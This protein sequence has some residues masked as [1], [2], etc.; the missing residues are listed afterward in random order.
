MRENANRET[1]GVCTLA[2]LAEFIS[3]TLIY[4]Y[5][6][7]L[8]Y[9]VSIIYVVYYKKKNYWAR[10]SF[11]RLLPKILKMWTTNSYFISNLDK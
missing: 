10:I 11:L 6:I 1:I 2:Y 5:L 3:R 8:S 7:Y 9:L 4:I